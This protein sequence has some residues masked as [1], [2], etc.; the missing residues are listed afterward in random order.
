MA[1]RTCPKCGTR[2]HPRQTTQVYCS[3]PCRSYVNVR[4]QIAR[5]Y[6]QTAA[7]KARRAKYQRENRDRHIDRKRTRNREY[8]RTVRLPKQRS[9]AA[10]RKAQRRLLKAARGTRGMKKWAAGQCRR[11]G[12]SFI[13]VANKA[14]TPAYCST[15]CALND[16][17]DRRRARQ[18]G[19]RLISSDAR[20]KVFERDGW[21][22]LLC[23]QPVNRQAV[24][25]ADD[26]P[27]IDHRKPLVAGGDHDETNWQTAH[28]KCNVRKGGAWTNDLVA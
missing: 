7:E 2:F 19:A 21:L 8:E 25:P 3:K 23:G 17:S 18:G 6:R 14:H 28:F 11:C 4:A 15:R 9:E 10:R 12:S 13:G 5:G 26:A 16:K 20:W 27:T 24:V 1:E 22:C